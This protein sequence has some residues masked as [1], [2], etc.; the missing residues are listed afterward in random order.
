MIDSVPRTER[1]MCL[2]H[3]STSSSICR[4]SIQLSVHSRPRVF[5]K[6][7]AR[8]PAMDNTGP[9]ATHRGSEYH[10]KS[11][12]YL[13]RTAIAERISI[14]HVRSAGDGAESGAF[15][16]TLGSASLDG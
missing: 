10:L 11:E 8:W 1:C 12:L 15:T 2:S 9:L 13:S 16:V 7:R 4:A 3:R 5:R 6:S 14:R